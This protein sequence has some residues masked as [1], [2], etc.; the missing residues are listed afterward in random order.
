[1]QNRSRKHERNLKLNNIKPESKSKNQ[2]ISMYSNN[3]SIHE[4]NTN[5]LI[6]K[7]KIIKLIDCMQVPKQFGIE[8]QVQILMAGES[9]LYLFSRGEIFNSEMAVCFIEKELDSSRKFLNFAVIENSN[10]ESVIK[11]LKKQEIPKASNNIL[12]N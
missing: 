5:N 3:H 10:D 11:T 9:S 7:N 2:S 6:L 12:L 8:L 1:M 4:G